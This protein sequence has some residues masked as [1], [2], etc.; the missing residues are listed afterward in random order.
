MARK[1]LKKSNKPTPDAKP[2]EKPAEEPA[3]NAPD[4]EEEDLKF[5][6]ERTPEE[7]R[8]A[9]RDAVGAVVSLV[10]TL[11]LFVACLLVWHF[12]ERFER[13]AIV[14][15]DRASVAKEEYILESGAGQ[16]FA[17]AGSGLAAASTSGLELLDE[18]A[19][20]AASRLFPMN[21]P[22][23]AACAEFA[24][25][26]DLGGTNMVVAR[27]DGTTRELTCAGDIISATVSQGGVIAVTTECTG[28]RA[29]VTVYNS[30]LDPIYEW[31]SSSA[32]VMTAAVS[33]DG[34]SMAVLVY[35]AAGSEVRF[36]SLTKTEQQAELVAE[37]TLLLDLHWISGSQLCAYSSEAAWFFSA[38]G[39]LAS[40]YSF[41]GRYL[42]ACT[43]DSA[44]C[45]VF[46]LSD[47]RSGTTET[48]V[49]LDTAGAVLG[50]AE[51]QSEI[52]A[53]TAS[54]GEVLVLCP[55]AA[56]LLS[57]SLIEKGRLYGVTGFKYGILR[58]RGEALLISTNY[59]EVYTFD[60]AA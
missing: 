37:D 45:A 38:K 52:I 4:D 30:A 2:E 51:L 56:V 19:G 32:W 57:G 20:L 54:G 27:F 35:T 33:P 12:R 59:A 16:V 1:R 58:S 40:M 29:L 25:F 39:E 15:S 60:S 13:D 23:I 14:V 5:R 22:A 43:F 11:V 21:T 36:F 3:E 9:R 8:A 49:S 10:L 17:Q 18:N 26:Y 46:A 42:S 48:L 47:Y 44:G 50:T 7:K 24:L 28:Y 31:Y 53:L 6:I 34:R 55:D 41:E